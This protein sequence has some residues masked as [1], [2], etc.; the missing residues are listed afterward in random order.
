MGKKVEFVVVTKNR[1]IFFYSPDCAEILHTKGEGK[2]YRLTEY[3][4]KW[5][6]T[7]MFIRI[8]KNKSLVRKNK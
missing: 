3:V 1:E 4:N 7:L 5:E 6:S 2:C 8:K